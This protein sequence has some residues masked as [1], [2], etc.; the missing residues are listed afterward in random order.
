MNRKSEMPNKPNQSNFTKLLN[1]IFESSMASG[2][3][4]SK[5]ANNKIQKSMSKY[6]KHRKIRNKMARKSRRIN[7]N[8]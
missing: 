8:V 1:I 6:A 3:N 4:E 7:R 5:Y 2:F